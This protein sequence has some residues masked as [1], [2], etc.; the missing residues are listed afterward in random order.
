MRIL[1]IS[2]FV[3]FLTSC[4]SNKERADKFLKSNPKYLAE[5]CA[6][7]FP[8]TT[9]YIKGA[10]TTDTVYRSVPGPIMPCPEYEDRDGNKKQPKVK[11]P[12]QL[13]QEVTTQQIDTVYVENTANVL[14]L[15]QENLA[16]AD[17]V[18]SLTEDNDN[19][20]KEKRN[21]NIIIGAML[22]AFLMFRSK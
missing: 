7:N 11:C 14:R 21:R 19:L 1:A 12:D 16:L 3:L 17:K 22:I 2:I 6:I 13:I 5:Q 18:D 20:K 10:K 8:P 15:K 9:K 4:A